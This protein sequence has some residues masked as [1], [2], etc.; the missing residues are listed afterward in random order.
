MMEPEEE[1]SFHGA[2]EVLFNED[3]R[4]TLQLLA[5]ENYRG[6]LA[7]AVSETIRLGLLVRALCRGL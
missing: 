7:T 5:D 4:F 3:E 6:N 1:V 2:F